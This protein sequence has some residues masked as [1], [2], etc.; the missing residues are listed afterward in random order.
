MGHPRATTPSGT[1]KHWP[2]ASFRL[3]IR[4]DA[5]DRGKTPWIEPEKE[6]SK[7]KTAPLKR[8]CEKNLL[9]DFGYRRVRKSLD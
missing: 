1:L 2:P 8:S 5:V 3:L 9:M 6:E 7:S 4:I